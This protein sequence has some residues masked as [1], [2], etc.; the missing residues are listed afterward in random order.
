MGASDVG[1]LMFRLEV[2]TTRVIRLQGYIPSN[3]YFQLIEVLRLM[4]TKSY[5]L[6]QNRGLNGY[7]TSA[8]LNNHEYSISS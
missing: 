4:R 2:A 5:E 8:I 7:R 3:A 1:E 6:G